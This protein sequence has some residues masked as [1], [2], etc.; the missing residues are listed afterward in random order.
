MST[1]QSSLRFQT[2]MKNFRGRVEIILLMALFEM[3]WL[4]IIS[5][6][7]LQRKKPLERKLKLD[8]KYS[9]AFYSS[10]PITSLQAV[11]A[12][13]SSPSSSHFWDRSKMSLWWWAIYL[14]YFLSWLP[15]RKSCILPHLLSELPNKTQLQDLRAR[16]SDQVR[17]KISC[18]SGKGWKDSFNFKDQTVIW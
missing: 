11:S 12:T 18:R 13:T 9:K 6:E 1:C 3:S 16:A 4:W 5:Y 2:F 10:F 7:Q 17:N 14:N 8:Q 15:K